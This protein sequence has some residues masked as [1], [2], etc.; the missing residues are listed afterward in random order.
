MLKHWVANTPDSRGGRT[1]LLRAAA[2]IKQAA[3]SEIPWFDVHSLHDPTN[4]Y[5]SVF[6]WAV[7]NGFQSRSVVC[8]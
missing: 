6:P 5:Y 7:S 4:Q 8:I 1:T 2:A 3:A